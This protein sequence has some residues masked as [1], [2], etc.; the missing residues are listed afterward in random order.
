MMNEPPGTTTISGH[1]SQSLNTSPARWMPGVTASAA[2]GTA[3]WIPDI[4]ASVASAN[5]SPG[6]PVSHA[7]ADS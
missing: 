3:R 7:R 6:R 1:S 4:T 2:T 5:A